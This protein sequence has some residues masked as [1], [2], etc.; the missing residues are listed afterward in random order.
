MLSPKVVSAIIVAM[1]LITRFCKKL[2]Y[3]KNITVLTNGTG[4]IDEDDLSSITDRIRGENIN[5]TLLY[6]LAY[7]LGYPT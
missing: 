2:K 3:V 4:F 5:L 6:A 7:D 1:D